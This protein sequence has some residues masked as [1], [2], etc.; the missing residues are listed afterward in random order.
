MSAIEPLIQVQS[1]D[2]VGY[3]LDST[4][5]SDNRGVQLDVSN[6]NLKVYYQ[7]PQEGSTFD[8]R[9]EGVQEENRGAPILLVGVGK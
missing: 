4:R 9:A 1:G 6:S 7:P 5:E 3:Y 2:V 8:T